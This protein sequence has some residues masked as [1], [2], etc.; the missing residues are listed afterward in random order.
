M[1]HYLVNNF[2]LNKVNTDD[3]WTLN[4]KSKCSLDINSLND[5]DLIYLHGYI[6]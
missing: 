3:N 6:D 5:E 4:I 2:Y 1:R